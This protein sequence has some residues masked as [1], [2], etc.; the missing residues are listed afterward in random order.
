M[1]Q[2]QQLIVESRNRKLAV[3]SVKVHGV[4][5]TN[6]E[7]LERVTKPLLA[8]QTLGDV[9]VGSRNI[10]DQLRRFDIFKNVSIVLDSPPGAQDL[11]DVV[12]RVEE[13]KRL[14]AQTG[15]SFG[16]NDGSMNLSI[17]MRN[18]FGGA[19]TVS[20]TSMYGV[21]TAEPLY[22]KDSKDMAG[23]NAY[24]A[25][26]STPIDAD[27]DRRLELAG[28]KQTRNHSLLM[29]HHERLTGLAAKYKQLFGDFAKHELSYDAVWRENHSFLPT[30]SLSIRKDAGHS[31]KSALSHTFTFD[32]RDDPNIPTR[33]LYLR[34]FQEL[35]G[36]GGD[37]RHLKTEL[38]TQA[39]IPLPFGFNISTS[40]RGGL[41]YP[42]GFGVEPRNRVNDRFFLGG[43]QSI[44]GF[45]Q[46]GVGPKDGSDSLGGDAYWASSLSLLGPIPFVPFKPI[47]AH[48][49]VNGGSLV[50]VALDK[51]PRSNLQSL[52]SSPSV[53]AGIGLAAHF[54]SIRLEVNYCVPLWV[55]PTDSIKP[56][57]KFG[58]G[59]NF[60]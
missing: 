41:I 38:D 5:H 42:L 59:M 4:V 40:L 1:S 37:V 11:V 60:M 3:Q 8:A 19:E 44:R 29:S 30:A 56:G 14:F 57:F 54:A 28:F 55:T 10:A 6:H 31:L 39:S 13:S 46:A 25:T 2:Q 9:I 16:A 21:D 22:L 12:F 27:P 36:L 45:K 49:F 51:S 47:K 58:I 52:V 24:Q 20:M 17:S 34:T 33:G 53:S 43:P 23:A 32:S 7:L 26:F 15:A 18:A 50:P 35:A 48:L